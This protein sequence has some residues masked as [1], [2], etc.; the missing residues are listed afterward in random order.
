M[1]Q[2]IIKKTKDYGNVFNTNTFERTRPEPLN[3][4]EIH[5]RRKKMKDG[6]D[7]K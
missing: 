7:E 2:I 6:V 3:W 1:S 4:L 5:D